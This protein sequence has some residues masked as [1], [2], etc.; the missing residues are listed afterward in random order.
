MRIAWFALVVLVGFVLTPKVAENLR[1]T[2]SSANAAMYQTVIQTDPIPH[3][4]A[5]ADQVPRLGNAT[6]F[7]F[8]SESLLYVAYPTRD[9]MPLLPD[10]PAP[11]EKIAPDVVP[12]LETAPAALADR[13]A[14]ATP[15]VVITVP[16]DTTPNSVKPTQ[17]TPLVGLA[18]ND[19]LARITANGLNMRSGPGKNFRPVD[20][21]GTGDQVRITGARK[22]DWIPVRDASSGRKGWV[23]HRYIRPL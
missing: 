10:I 4:E 11:I 15:K 22:G 2:H 23:H 13:S 18:P 1:P 8:G 7:A 9:T 5:A 3:S 17:I 19:R 14:E 12:Q 16:A 21:L 6:M 20:V